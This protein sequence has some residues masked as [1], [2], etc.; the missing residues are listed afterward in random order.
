MNMKNKQMEKDKRIDELVADL[1]NF[2]KKGGAHMD[3]I[4]NSDSDE[5]EISTSYNECV[6]G[7]GAC[8]I[9]TESDD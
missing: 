9:P 7:K 1:D 6:E 5:K 8:G 2:F 4:V 3:I